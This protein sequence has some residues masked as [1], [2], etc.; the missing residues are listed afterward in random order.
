MRLSN[1]PTHA[2]TS[3]SVPSAIPI[4]IP[5]PIPI[6]Y[7]DTLSLHH[8]SHS[9]SPRCSTG[10]WLPRRAPSKSPFPPPPSPSP[11]L[12]SARMLSLGLFFSSTVFFA[13][14]DYRYTGKPGGS[15]T[16]PL[17]WCGYPCRAAA[18]AAARYCRVLPLRS[19]C[20]SGWLVV[21]SAPVR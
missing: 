6:R 14:C 2:R 12:Y 19:I 5:I 15:D 11:L 16:Y 21:R 10:I 1:V 8:Q 18:A 20:H 4:P 7:P 13:C 9:P 3:L 17:L